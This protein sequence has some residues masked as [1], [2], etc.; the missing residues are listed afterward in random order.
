MKN[1]SDLSN[2]NN[3]LAGVLQIGFFIIVT[4][5]GIG[6]LLLIIHPGSHRSHVLPPIQALKES[7]SLH[8]TPILDIGIIILLGMPPLLLIITLFSFLR[9]GE[10]KFAL[11]SFFVLLILAL[12]FFLG[13]G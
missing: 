11:I 8:P 3:L 1:D 9:V 6:I 13:K 10:K 12:S 7:L 2:L 5:I 4:I